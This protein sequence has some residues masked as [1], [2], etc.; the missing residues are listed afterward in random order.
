[1]IELYHIFMKKTLLISSAGKEKR[2][3]FTLHNFFRYLFIELP[4]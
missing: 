2:E 3:L 4:Y 1:M